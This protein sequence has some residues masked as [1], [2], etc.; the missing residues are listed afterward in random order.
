MIDRKGRTMKKRI[1]APIILVLYIVCFVCSPISAQADSKTEQAKASTGKSFTYNV[2]HPEN[3]KSKVGYFDLRMTPGQKQT[4]KIELTNPSDKKISVGISLNG[5]KTNGNGVLEYGPTSIE[6]DKSLKYDFVNI[7]KGAEKVDIPAGETVPLELAIDMPEASF[8]GVISGGIEM[9]QLPDETEEKK[10]QTGIVNEYAFLVGMLLSETDQPVEPEMAMNR[11]YAELENYRNAI[12]V[13]MSNI[14][15]E[16]LNEVTTDV[17]IMKKGSDEVLYDKKKASM[18]IGPN[19]M[20]DFP[21]SMN[22]DKMVPGDYVAHVLVVSGEK[23]WEWTEN[24]K[25]T[26]EEADKFN[27]QDVS[28]LQERG[29]DWKLIGMIVAGVIVAVLIIFFIVRSVNKKKKRSKK[30]KPKK[31]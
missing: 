11:V 9:K 26:D 30:R 12:F 4:V 16:Y 29:I 28:L 2:V 25:I 19:N 20:I 6:N 10:E 22:G 24:F 27:S 7:V 21:V 5:V 3:Q 8:E 17:Q 14:K 1:V 15:P 18:R 23:R 13:S 31:K